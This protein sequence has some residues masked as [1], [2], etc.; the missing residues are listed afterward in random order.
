MEKE[1][2]DWKAWFIDLAESTTNLEKNIKEDIRES[3][4]TELEDGIEYLVL[5]LLIVHAEEF[6]QFSTSIYVDREEIIR[7]IQAT[8]KVLALLRFLLGN[9]SPLITEVNNRLMVTILSINI[10]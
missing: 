5:P 9:Q 2:Q 3:K 4:Y 1:T 8:S 6:R 7:S 10:T